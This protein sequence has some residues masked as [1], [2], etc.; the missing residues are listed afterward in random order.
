MLTLIK[1][2]AS[3]VPTQVVWDTFEHLLASQQCMSIPVVYGR[4]S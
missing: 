3:L 2:Q 4:S 1:L